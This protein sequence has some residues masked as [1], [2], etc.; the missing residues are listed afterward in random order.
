[1]S[2][3]NRTPNWRWCEVSDTT[4]NGLVTPSE[5]APIPHRWECSLRDL[6]GRPAAPK[7]IYIHVPYCAT[8]CG[9]CDFNTYTPRE[10]DLAASDYARLAVREIEMAGSLWQ[11][12]GVDTVFIGGGT[13][14]LLST[15]DIAA[16]ITAV[17]TVFTLAPG[18]EVTIE[19]NPDSVDERSLAALLDAGVTRVSFGV[20]SL[21]PHVLEVLE[22]THTPGSAL[23]AIERARTVGFRHI[24]ADLIYATPGETDVDL[25][26]SVRAVLEA[27][28]DHL[29]AY[30]LIVEPGTRLAQRV[31]RGEVPAPDDDVAAERYA[32]IDHIAREAGLEWYEVSNWARPGGECRHNLGY[33]RGGDWWAIGPGAHGHLAGADRAVRWWNVKHPASYGREVAQGCAPIAGF[34]ELDADMRRI[35]STMLG[36]RLREGIPMDLIPAEQRSNLDDLLTRGWVTLDDA[37]LRLTDAGRLLADRVVRELT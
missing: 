26:S 36:L 35:E 8:R 37:C 9:Y 20:Q 24:S 13:P 6:E 1:M 29:S 32:L 15:D 22:R 11:P 34:E 27:G 14:T 25:E 12:G 21:A 31:H 33:W 10:I 28:V 7:G 5:E 18:A 2:Y 16:V 3:L 23:A 4:L 30:S 19:A 17:T